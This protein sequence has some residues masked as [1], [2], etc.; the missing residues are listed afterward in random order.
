MEL[1]LLVLIKI[2]IEIE[3]V[4]EKIWIF[5]ISSNSA[6]A[7][8]KNSNFPEMA[9]LKQNYQQNL[10]FNAVAKEG[11]LGHGPRHLVYRFSNF[12]TREQFDFT[13]DIK[14]PCYRTTH[15]RHDIPWLSKLLNFIIKRIK[16]YISESLVSCL[17]CY[18]LLIENLCCK[19]AN[20]GFWNVI[21][22]PHRR[23][24]E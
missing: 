19:S 24:Y 2:K 17:V 20:Y 14:K 1:D 18:L 6:Q 10:Q 13:A 5:K 16:T 4:Q 9:W 12:S 23:W 21:N 22:R 11:W 8:F 7:V 15:N 3:D